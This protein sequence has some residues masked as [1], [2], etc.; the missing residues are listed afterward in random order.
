MQGISLRNLRF[1]TALSTALIEWGMFAPVQ[2]KAA[3]TGS[4]KSALFCEGGAVSL[5]DLVH[6]RYAEIHKR[7]Q[8]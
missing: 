4:C 5:I 8:R 1:K 7:W 2:S 6:Q 3:S